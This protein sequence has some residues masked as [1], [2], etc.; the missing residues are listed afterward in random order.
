M[1]NYVCPPCLGLVAETSANLTGREQQGGYLPEPGV[2]SS[3]GFLRIPLGLLFYH[4]LFYLQTTRTTSIPLSAGL[5]TKSLVFELP[6]LVACSLFN[7]RHAE[8]QSVLAPVLDKL[9][10]WALIASAI[11]L[12]LCTCPIFFRPRTI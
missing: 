7:T 10:A 6:P 3:D 4:H 11:V 12:H 5:S 2:A 8:L 9:P 1:E